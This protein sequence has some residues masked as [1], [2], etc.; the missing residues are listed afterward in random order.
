MENGGIDL[1]IGWN[2]VPWPVAMFRRKAAGTF[3]ISLKR[4]RRGSLA[5][6]ALFLWVADVGLEQAD[7]DQG[8]QHGDGAGEQGGNGGVLSSHG[9]YLLKKCCDAHYMH[10]PN[11]VFKLPMRHEFDLIF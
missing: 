4:I 8:G 7:G 5:L 10:L 3:R 1:G 2:I 11:A 6:R 9:I